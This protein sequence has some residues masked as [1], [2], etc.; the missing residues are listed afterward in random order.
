MLFHSS[1]RAAARAA[2]SGVT[3]GGVATA[4]VLCGALS[5]ARAETTATVLD[6]S[7][8]ASVGGVERA[9]FDASLAE[10]LRSQQLVVTAKSDRD[11]I[12]TEEKRLQSCQTAVCI[13]R[14]GRLLGSRYVIHAEVGVRRDGPTPGDGDV[15][16][17]KS[18]RLHAPKTTPGD[19]TG[20]IARARAH[21]PYLCHGLDRLPA[22]ECLLA[23]G[24]IEAALD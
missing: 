5:S 2:A 15:K 16:K 8:D 7:S 12:F 4:L 19:W 18:G 24:N 1:R 20:A 17:E 10:T 13:E 11:L 6:T 9:F 21:A 14:I 3:L 23:A 22:L